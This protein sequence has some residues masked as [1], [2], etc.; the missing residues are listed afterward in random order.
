MGEPFEILDHTADTG[1]RAFGR[2]LPELYANAALAMLHLMF[3][4]DTVRP[5]DAEVVEVE[6]SDAVDLM[7]AWLHEIIFR[8]DAHKR[9]FTGVS[10]EAFEEWRLRATL[11][12]EPFDPAR[13]E[14][15]AEVKAV[16]WHRARVER[17]GDRWVTELLFDV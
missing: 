15:L 4:P 12:G 3:D 8:F 13:H 10:I 7:V 14:L 1:I 5:D 17:E 2:A 6:G 11:R 9:L 16:T